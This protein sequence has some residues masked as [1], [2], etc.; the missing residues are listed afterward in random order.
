M[1]QLTLFLLLLSGAL[2]FP[3]EDFTLLLGG[4]AINAGKGDPEVLFVLCYV[5]TI[6]GDLFIYG[7]GRKFGTQLFN[8]PWVKQ[9]FRPGRV[10]LVRKGLE[11]RGFPTI[12]IARHLFYLRTLTFITCGAVRMNFMRFLLADCVSA[13]VS[14]PLML[15]LGYTASEHYDTVVGYLK[16]AKLVSMVIILVGGAAITAYFIKRKKQ[17]EQEELEEEIRDGSDIQPMG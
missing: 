12:F 8:K 10:K 17:Q 15:W 7:V 6:L 1:V 9:R 3:P 2:G 5:G 11:K 16:Q 4:I 14:V 13:L